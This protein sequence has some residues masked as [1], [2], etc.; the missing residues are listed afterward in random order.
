KPVVAFLYVE[1]YVPQAYNL[2]KTLSKNEAENIFTFVYSPAAA[3]NGNGGTGGGQGGG[4]NVPGA[5][6]DGNPGPG[7]A[8][9]NAPGEETGTEGTDAPGGENVT[10]GTDAPEGGNGTGIQ[11][12]AG[13]ADTALG[14]AGEEAGAQGDAPESPLELLDLE[15]EEVPL[16]MQELGQEGEDRGEVTEGTGNAEKLFYAEI[17]MA[18]IAGAALIFLG[19]WW[20]KRRRKNESEKGNG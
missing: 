14:A 8:G 7:T 6:G 1:G 17:A 19:I 20:W 2:T 3:G 18:C 12:G 13:G 5:V 10:A 9:T 16:A 4:Q 15:D 11:E